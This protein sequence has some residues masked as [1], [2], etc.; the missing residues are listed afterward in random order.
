[1]GNW[2]EKAVKAADYIKNNV[3]SQLG[4]YPEPEIAL[5]LG[6]CF[7]E[8]VKF[9]HEKAVIS[10]SEI[11]DFT[12]STVNGHSGRLI[13]CRIGNRW[14]YVMQ[15]RTHYYEGYEMDAVVLPVRVFSLLG[16]RSMVITN[17]AGGINSSYNVGDFVAL[18]DHL[19]FCAPSPLRGPNESEFGLRFPSMDNAY[20]C[21]LRKIA[22]Q[23]AKEQKIIM[24]TGVYAYMR[25]P[26]F[27]TPAEIRA[28][29]L[30]G[31]D[32]VGMS[33]VPEVIAARHCNIKIAGFSCVTNMAA[34]VTET[35]V[36]HEDVS[37]TEEMVKEDFAPFIEK[38]VQLI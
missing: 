38:F 11:P 19:S 15:G 3:L 21:N 30:L 25:G 1:M 7:G 12:Q 20:D 10:Y 18:S 29:R 5:V 36:S 22:L 8:A 28:L 23:C 9:S 33:T 32:V 14:C 17:A 31:G 13:C 4:Y 34:G 24:H 2:Y 37:R 26:Q 35:A 6:T 16:I 27:E